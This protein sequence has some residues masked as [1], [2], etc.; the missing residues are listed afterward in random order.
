MPK[1]ESC[2]HCGADLHDGK[3]PRSYEQLKRHFAVA[4][5]A[6]MHWP[7]SE[8]EQP[9]NKEHMRKHLEMRA[10]WR[11]VGASVDL[12]GV[13]PD[14]AL[15]LAKAAIL[16]AGT[17][18]HPVIHNGQLVVWRP[19]SI[20]FNKMGHEE[21]CK[22]NNAVDEVIYEV[23]GITGDELLEQTEKAA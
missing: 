18:A 14:E 22:L 5:A 17:Y 16:G 6:Y 13:P 8:R 21:F 7:E 9:G 10:G 11:I 20:A 23:F 1:L 12:A 2:P 15:L 19:K 3:V 4:A